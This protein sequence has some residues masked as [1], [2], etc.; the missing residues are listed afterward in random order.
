MTCDFNKGLLQEFAIGEVSGAERREVESHLAHCIHCRAEVAYQRQLARDLAAVP[1]PDFPLELEE[2]LIR[3]SIQAAMTGEAGRSIKTSKLQPA[4]V[5]ALGSAAGLGIIILLVLLLWPA[6]VTTW[7]G[8]EPTGGGQGLGLLDG[9]TRWIADFRAALQT[10]Q[11]FFSHF[12]PVLKA[13]RMALGALGGSVWAALILG[14]L[15]TTLLLWRISSAGKKT[16]GID[17]AKQHS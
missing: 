1:E 14:A 6:R 8:L 16:R 9:V 15:S 2:V 12:A 11:D 4:W 7:G 5:L 10:V 3:S 17:H 13:V